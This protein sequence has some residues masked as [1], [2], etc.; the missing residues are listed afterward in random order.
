MWLGAG[1]LLVLLSSCYIALF[2]VIGNF[3]EG[4]ASPESLSIYVATFVGVM[5]FSLFASG[6]YQLRLA[7]NLR[8][9]MI[10]LAVSAVL[11]TLL[12][13]GLFLVAPAQ[14]IAPNVVGVCFFTAL[15]G[16]IG[17]RLLFYSFCDA[18]ALQRQVLVI[19]TGKR[20]AQLADGLNH[21]LIRGVNLCGFVPTNDQATPQINPNDIIIPDQ[22]I[23]ALVAELEVEE[24]VIAL[25]DRRGALPA[26]QI[27]ECKMAGT[28]VT[29]LLDFF[30]RYTGAI[31]IESLNPS[32][33]IY[34]EGFSGAAMGDWKKRVFDLFASSLLL[35]VALPIMLI[36]AL[37][38]LIECGGREPVFYRQTRVGKGGRHFKVFKF[39][40]M[41]SGAEKSGA[42]WA[43]ANDS[44]VTR[45]GRFIRQTRIDELP[46]L[47]NVFQGDMSFVGPRPERPEFVENLNKSIPYYDI[48]HKT[49]PGITGWAQVC[50]P[51]GASEDDARRKLQYD[52]YY[53]K[54]HSL[55]LDLTILF[56][57][58][59]VCLWRQGAR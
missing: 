51:Y 21:G 36:T 38:I 39:R 27:L 5:L 24:I 57:T 33:M 30:E 56:Q 4:Q 9:T 48:R 10:R 53:M 45:V 18:T 42:Q 22:D 6:L 12:T 15:L 31:A 37:A 16:L 58:V 46:Q 11:G 23:R 19:G 17:T 7:D 8:S 52:L 55:F 25:D 47:L 49:L 1:E 54:N 2:L 40:S 35:I 3:N 41:C 59:Q 29:E 26:E 43:T 32:S 44:R 14:W 13:G 20:A 34:S 50:Y 28:Q